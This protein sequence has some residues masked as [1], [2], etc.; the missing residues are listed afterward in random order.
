MLCIVPALP[1]TRPPRSFRWGCASPNFPPHFLF[2]FFGSPLPCSYSISPI[3]HALSPPCFFLPRYSLCFNY[4]S[5]LWASLLSSLR[6]YITLLFVFFLVSSVSSLQFT[7]NL[8]LTR[9]NFNFQNA[10]GYQFI[11]CLLPHVFLCVKCGVSNYH[12]SYL[13]TW[14]NFLRSLKWVGILNSLLC[15]DY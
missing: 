2:H 11:S 8:P 3:S 15:F 14:Y 13:H 6:P 7:P 10:G 12:W 1:A 4:E 9:L 5:F